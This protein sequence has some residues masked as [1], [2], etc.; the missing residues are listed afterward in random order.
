MQGSSDATTSSQPTA[1][2]EQ[3]HVCDAVPASDPARCEEL[4]DHDKERILALQQAILEATARGAAPLEIVNRV[5]L[6]EEQMVP[7]AVA[8]VMLLD[9]QRQSLHVYSAP[10]VPPDGIARL[11]GLRPGPGAGSCGNSVFSGEAVFVCNTSTDPR[12][13]DLRQLAIDFDLNACWS[14]PIRSNGGAIVGTFALSS[15]EHREPTAFHRAL[16][17]IG[18]SIVGIVLSRGREADERRAAEERIAFLAYHD[19]LTGLPN[20]LLTRERLDL[21]IALAARGGH[22]VALLFLDLDSF[23]VVNDSLGHSAGDL[24]LR[25]VAVRLKGCIRDGDTLG[26]LGGDEFVLIISDIA[27][28]DDVGYTSEKVL[29]QLSD[30]F[31]VEGNELT[32]TV[33]IGAAVYPDDGQDFE[34]LLKKADIAMYGA[35]GAGR[36]TYRF[37]TQEMNASAMEHLRIR[38]GLRQALDQGQFVLHFQPQVDLAT[39]Q[40]IG[41][42]ALIRWAHPQL[43]LLSP[44]RFISIAEDSGLIVPIGDWVLREACRQTVA[45]QAASGM[46]GLVC[47]VNLSAP[48]FRRGELERSVTRALAES[49]LEPAC[50]DLE[51]TESLLVLDTEQV[52]ATV[53][54]LKLIGVTLCID[55]FGTGYSSLSYL[56]RFAVD[57]LKIDRSFVLGMADN[58]NDAA[59]VRAIIQM[60]HSLGLR[61]TGEGIEDERQRALLCMH[62][63]D[64]GQGFYFSRPLPAHDLLQYA[65]DDRERR[66][67][68]AITLFPTA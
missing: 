65:L 19:A 61:T 2:R 48:Q 23:K 54:R 51:L 53:Q 57:K 40:M 5:C 17:D 64:H 3:Q 52:L 55:D 30:P 37:Y 20:R 25:A 28:P 7:N 13:A 58:P 21:A 42:E 45:L 44:D 6:L 14:V 10:S 63:C 62:G 4:T 8:S 59:I 12:W 39:G 1:M 26:R 24:L 56:K 18:A 67:P 35:K 38:T 16:L 33:S 49:G 22:K 9:E 31:E 41:I 43:G 47:A 15:F 46:T 36:N 60:A 11:N 50:L 32:T 68:K 66:K 27:N 34:T 29:A